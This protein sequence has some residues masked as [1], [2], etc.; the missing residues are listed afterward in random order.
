MWI[1]K[2]WQCISPTVILN[3]FKKCCISN[4]VD[5][6]DDDSCGMVMQRMGILGAGER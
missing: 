6:S 1:I 5:E 3:G 2:A 4:A